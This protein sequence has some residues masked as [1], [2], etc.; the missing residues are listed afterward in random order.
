MNTRAEVAQAFD[1][2]QAGKMG[3]IPDHYSGF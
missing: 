2:F 1:D 3:R